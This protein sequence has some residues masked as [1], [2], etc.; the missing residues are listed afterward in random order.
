MQREVCAMRDPQLVNLTSLTNLLRRHDRPIFAALGIVWLI[1]AFG[2]YRGSNWATWIWPWTDSDMTYVFLASLA[3]AVAVPLGWLAIVNEPAGAAGLA[4]DA[5]GI[6]GTC[7]VSLVAMGATGDTGN[8]LGYAAGFGISAVLG[9]IVFRATGPLSIRDETPLPHAV[10]ILFLALIAASA[11]L[12]VSLMLRLDSVYAWDLPPKTSTLIGAWFL[13]AGLS[14]VFAVARNSWVHAGATLVAFLAYDAV[15]FVPYMRA[16]FDPE[17]T[18]ESRRY[19]MYSESAAASST[20][21]NGASLSVYLIVLALGGAVAVYFLFIHRETR[22]W[23]HLHLEPS[24][25]AASIE[26]T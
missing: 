16:A 25:S 12:G 1:L 18:A 9:W 24:L 19:P 11:V 4:L 2:L 6:G 10:R 20:D 13:G 21:V 3:A 8:L 7:A 26:T 23:R 5:T 17:G 22:I 14:F 15:Q